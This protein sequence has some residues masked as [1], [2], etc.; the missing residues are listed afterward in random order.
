MATWE[1]NLEDEQCHLALLALAKL[2]LE[3]PGFDFAIREVVGK[4]PSGALKLYESLY[5]SN[6]DVAPSAVGE[7]CA[8]IVETGLGHQLEGS[9]RRAQ[10][11]RGR[12]SAICGGP[13]AVRAEPESERAVMKRFA[14]WV[15]IG[16]KCENR[17]FGQTFA[18]VAIARKNGMKCII[19]FK[20][21]MHFWHEIGLY[22]TPEQM[23]KTEAAWKSNGHEIK[24]KK[25]SGAFGFDVNCPEDQWYEPSMVM[26]LEHGCYGGVCATCEAALRKTTVPS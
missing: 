17:R 13:G 22:G 25:P 23:R 6:A 12:S 10:D 14:R 19:G 8:K 1:I 11:H 24:T 5:A 26:R 7:T 16:G 21:G 20:P 18:L 9:G 4:F 2:S 15:S 3:R